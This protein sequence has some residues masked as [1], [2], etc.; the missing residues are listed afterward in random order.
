MHPCEN[1]LRGTKFSSRFQIL[2]SNGKSRI[3]KRG[4]TH[5]FGVKT[6]DLARFFAEICIKMKEVG[7]GGPHIHNPLP[8]F[9]SANGFV[10]LNQKYEMET[11]M[12]HSLIEA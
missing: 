3:S 1:V 5:E 11:V 10:K 6:Y 12:R 7:L 4:T 2:D 8:L 9:R